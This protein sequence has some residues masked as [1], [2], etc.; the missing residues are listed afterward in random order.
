MV[1]LSTDS[2]SP[3]IPVFLIFLKSNA[4]EKNFKHILGYF[5]PGSMAWL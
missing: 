3:H 5:T 1:L 2:N 4:N